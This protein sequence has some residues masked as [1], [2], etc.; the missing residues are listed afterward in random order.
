MSLYD[1]LVDPHTKYM[2]Q[3][4]VTSYAETEILVTSRKKHIIQD[5]GLLVLKGTMGWLI[6]TLEPASRQEGWTL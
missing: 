5:V 4:N 3:A 1:K 6:R 2:F